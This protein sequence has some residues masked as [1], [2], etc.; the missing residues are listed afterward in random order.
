[1]VSKHRHIKSEQSEPV[2]SGAGT[3]GGSGSVIGTI[4]T[5]YYHRELVRI[6]TLRDIADRYTG[7]VLGLIWAVVHPALII[8]VF[9][10]LFAFLFKQKFPDGQLPIVVSDGLGIP[11][12]LIS[13][14]IPWLVSVE[15]LS[16]SSTAITARYSMNMSAG[17]IIMACM[18]VP[19]MYR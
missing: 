10:F 4:K 7:Q 16:R 17:T 9:L 18:K 13:G 2:H 19:C 8:F 6:M 5:L 1:M 3:G 12:Y 15:I 14:L 11:V